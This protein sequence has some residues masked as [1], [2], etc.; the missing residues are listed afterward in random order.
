MT[1]NKLNDAEQPT[2]NNFYK[3]DNINFENAL[4]SADRPN[5]TTI[6]AFN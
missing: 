3:I 6:S 4:K 2:I 5:T 1:K